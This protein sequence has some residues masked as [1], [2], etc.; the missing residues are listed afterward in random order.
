MR[1]IKCADLSTYNS[2]FVIGNKS[3]KIL[4]AD[5]RKEGCLLN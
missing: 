5:L 2:N 3:G 1:G 4:T